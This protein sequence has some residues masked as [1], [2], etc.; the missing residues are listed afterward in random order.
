MKIEEENEE[1]EEYFSELEKERESSMHKPPETELLGMF[2]GAES[3]ISLK[4]SEYKEEIEREESDITEILQDLYEK[5]L[6]P[7]SI[8]FAEAIIKYFRIPQIIEYENH[9]K[10]LRRLEMINSKPSRV[11][12]I[13]FQERLERARNYPIAEIAR[14]KLKLIRSGARFMALCP[15]HN[16]KHPSFFIFP[17]AN[18]FHCF[19]C[20]EHGD[21]IKLTME[22]ESVNF[23]RAIQILNI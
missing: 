6:D 7:L 4:I 21:V 10:R 13:N 11:N 18:N 16:E 2:T 3:I 12:V 15:F 20:G 19:G 14:T 23:K 22:L 5:N 8:W 17:E 9:L 1:T